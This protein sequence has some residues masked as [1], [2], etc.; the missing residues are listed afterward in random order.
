V[1]TPNGWKIKE[2]N[3]AILWY[4]GNSALYELAA[5]KVRAGSVT[6]QM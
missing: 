4:S 5:E 6:P 3:L 2:W 1:R